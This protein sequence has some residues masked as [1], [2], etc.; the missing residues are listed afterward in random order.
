MESAS[1]VR[2]D[3]PRLESGESGFTLVELLVT[4]AILLIL[5]AL[6][7][8]AFEVYKRE[9]Y[10]K[11]SAQLLGQA[12]TALEAGKQ[13]S[14]SFPASVMTVDQTSPGPL[15]GATGPLLMPGFVVSKDYRLFVNHDPTC[16]SDLCLEDYIETKHCSTD[17]K[18]IYW[19]TYG[20]IEFTN[21]NAADPSGCP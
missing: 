7:M 4:V 16:S 1:D 12:R 15:T 19:R 11:S 13:D 6:S 9:A 18:T 14:E 20:G 21:L 17:G 8:S 5:G 3:S 2:Q 10:M